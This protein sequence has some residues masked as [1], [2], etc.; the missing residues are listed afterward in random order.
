M[1]GIETNDGIKSF[2]TQYQSGGGLTSLLGDLQITN[3]SIKKYSA[4]EAKNIKTS[5]AQQWSDNLKKTD[6]KI[7]DINSKQSAIFSPEYTID[8]SQNDVLNNIELMQTTLKKFQQNIL[9]GLYAKPFIIPINSKPIPEVL[10]K[11]E[12]L[13]QMTKLVNMLKSNFE[14]HTI[15]ISKQTLQTQIIEIGKLVVQ[16]NKLDERIDFEI[17]V[18]TSRIQY[19]DVTDPTNKYHETLYHD[20]L[21]INSSPSDGKKYTI[22]YTSDTP[23]SYTEIFSNALLRRVANKTGLD[24]VHKDILT[25]LKKTTGADFFTK[26]PA[27]NQLNALFNPVKSQMTSA[28]KELT[29]GG[30]VYD[31]IDEK[32]TEFLKQKQDF[33]KKLVEYDKIL[34]KFNTFYV[35]WIVH[36]IYLLTVTTRLFTNEDYVVYKYVNYGT[37]VYYINKLTG[38]VQRFKNRSQDLAVLYMQKYHYNTVYTLLYFLQNL[39][40]RMRRDALLNSY[41]RYFGK[42]KGYDV[43]NKTLQ[44]FSK[45]E[46]EAILKEMQKG[47]TATIG[48]LVNEKLDKIST[49]K[50]DFI[51]AQTSPKAISYLD[52]AENKIIDIF[53]QDT[54]TY[55]KANLTLFSHFIPI[56]DTYIALS[57]SK[58]G[59]YARINDR[60]EL[61]YRNDRLFDSHP[62]SKNTQELVIHD[63]VCAKWQDQKKLDPMYDE[64]LD[65]TFGKL[66][67]DY[68]LQ[69]SEVLD[70]RT[71]QGNDTISKYMTLAKRLQDG[72]STMILT[73]GYSGTGKTYTMF[74]KSGDSGTN[75]IQGILQCTVDTI[76]NIES[77]YYRIFELYGMGV[78]FEYYWNQDNKDIYQ[79]VY[80][81]KLQ[82]VND[83]IEID[84]NPE[85]LKTLDS[86]TNF[87]NLQAN[88]SDFLE[89][90]MADIDNGVFK[91]FEAF[92]SDIDNKRKEA[93]RVR[94]T[95]NNPES[96]RSILIHD[97]RIKF[98]DNDTKTTFVIIDLPGR[99]ELIDSYCTPTINFMKG[100]GVNMVNEDFY[101]YILTS[102]ILEPLSMATIYPNIVIDAVNSSPEYNNI[103]NKQ[104]T[105]DITINYK[106]VGSAW[107]E[108]NKYASAS[109]KHVSP[110]LITQTNV[111]FKDEL[112]YVTSYEIVS[113]NDILNLTPKMSFKNIT[114]PISIV[115]MTRDKSDFYLHVY[116]AISLLHRIIRTNNYDLLNEISKKICAESINDSIY[117]RLNGKDPDDPVILNAL[118][119]SR[120]LYFESYLYAIK[121][122]KAIVKDAISKYS[123]P[124]SVTND[125]IKL[126]KTRDSVLKLNPTIIDKLSLS[127]TYTKTP[128]EGIYINENIVGLMAYLLST[129]VQETPIDINSIVGDEGN[130]QVPITKQ[131]VDSLMLK[132]VKAD[133]ASMLRNSYR[134]TGSLTTHEIEY[135]PQNYDYKVVQNNIAKPISWNNVYVEN[136]KL[137]DVFDKSVS[138]YKSDRIFKYTHIM[139]ATLLKPYLQIKDYKIFYLMNNDPNKCAAQLKLF[140]KTAKIL[141]N[142]YSNT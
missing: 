49:F 52:I 13:V 116:L 139:L 93:G 101:K 83:H 82:T 122:D 89:I 103:I 12:K 99:E 70:S 127:Y 67:K 77:I 10:N 35:N 15:D 110:T 60:L 37:I 53:H 133:V 88:S 124:T 132:K 135:I 95:P 27:D 6:T 73:Y 104:L 123:S 21:N 66:G 25:N 39:R 65:S 31:Y 59:T 30:T 75:S 62:D 117:E 23:S 92:M 105:I 98:K 113:V 128:Y 141:K 68:T 125:E 140:T 142:F 84:G 119:Q 96:S 55:I 7:K 4:R 2:I 1:F 29:G 114:Q 54:H 18:L 72:V 129:A 87:V 41:V 100:I 107:P 3:D 48:N 71:I 112:L 136:A 63:S 38:I 47:V 9:V 32:I 28:A 24:D 51:S 45:V 43:K 91:K 76:T 33:E 42:S 111:A 64:I 120:E 69:F 126:M 85:E 86:I 109:T 56:L 106:P 90:S 50:A 118:R 57:Q 26:F 97:F 17:K 81:Y 61:M 14:N 36:H 78:A 20:P 94:E 16:M 5:V 134:S 121:E 102:T 11:K 108:F 115:N 46:Q 19:M 40:D 131:D 58:V 34:N 80:N 138:T 79:R 74:G 44:D 130:K 22:K 8:V 137:K